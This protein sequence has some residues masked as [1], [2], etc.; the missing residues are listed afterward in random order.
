MSLD[1]LND[2]HLSGM[3]R[4]YRCYSEAVSQSKKAQR[5]RKNRSLPSK[6]RTR[7]LGPL[8][9]DA[10]ITLLRLSSV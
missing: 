4:S 1:E 8:R 6:D 3:T 5:E 10:S 2:V 7:T 9:R